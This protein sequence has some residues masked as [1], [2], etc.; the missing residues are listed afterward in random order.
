MAVARGVGERP[1]AG[2]HRSGVEG[3]CVTT[4]L[5]L[6]VDDDEDVRLALVNLVR[7][8]GLT[9]RSHSTA[10]ALLASPD[11]ALARCIVTDISMPGL[12]GIELKQE[13]DYRGIVTPIVM[14]TAHF[15]WAIRTRALACNPFRLL[16]KPFDA[17]EFVATI[18]QALA[19]DPDRQL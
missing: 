16:T 6:I 9:A 17:A 10:G 1:S 8:M 15:E 4:T 19:I 11:V 18:E 14:I 7:S 13:L 12:S 2:I 3:A 5:V